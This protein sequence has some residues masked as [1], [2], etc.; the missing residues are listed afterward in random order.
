[1]ILVSPTRD[2][3]SIVKKL[4][5]SVTNNV[6]EYKACIF[7]F[8]ALIVVG[9]KRVEVLVDSKLVISHVNKE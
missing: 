2:W 5:F 1:M 4:D 7:G 8:D 3:I 6:S 9:I